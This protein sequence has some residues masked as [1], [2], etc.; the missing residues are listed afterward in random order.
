M[1]FI[2]SL[3]PIPPFL[4]CYGFIESTMD[5][6]VVPRCSKSCH[7]FVYFSIIACGILLSFI[8][9][10]LVFALYIKGRKIRKQETNMLGLSNK[11]IL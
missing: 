5:C 11:T 6:F 10:D 4:N 9:A 7:I 3:I 1:S 8:T 2:I